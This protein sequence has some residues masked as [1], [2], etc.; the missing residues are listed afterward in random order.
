MYNDRYDLSETSEGKEINFFPGFNERIEYLPDDIN[1][2]IFNND[3]NN[4]IDW[5]PNQVTH[6][7][8]GDDFNKPIDNF[9]NGLKFVRFGPNFSQSINCLP[10]SVEEIKLT[11]HYNH[12][13]KKLPKSLKTF[14]V[15][16]VL[17]I[18]YDDIEDS[19]TTISEPIPNYYKI[20]SDL[21]EKY[22]NIK[23]YY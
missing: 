21:K 3:Y 16:H 9:P 5:L 7:F 14:N 20:Y 10:D 4:Y 11:Q 6:I 22:P 23:F 15:Y 19:V 13:I 17:K 12:T 1:I 2:I 8:F 18:I